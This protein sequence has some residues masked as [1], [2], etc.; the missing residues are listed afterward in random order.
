MKALPL[1]LGL[2]ASCS[3]LQAQFIRSAEY[4][5]NTDPGYGNGVAIPL[6]QAGKYIVL[7]A[8]IPV[9]DLLPGL[10]NL[11]VRTQNNRGYWSLPESRLVYVAA[12]SGFAAPDL[13]AMEYFFDKDPGIGNGQQVSITENNTSD[14]RNILIN[15][16]DL[17]P[18]FHQLYI[19]VRNAGGYWSVSEARRF[20]VSGAVTTEVPA[21]EYF[22]DTDPGHGGGTPLQLLAGDSVHLVAEVELP[23]TQP[24]IHYMYVRT[25]SAEGVWSL[26]ESRV[27]YVVH[28]VKIGAI[29]AAEYF[30]DTDPGFG[31]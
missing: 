13:V 14:S 3:F 21:A 19:R 15:L 25:R 5:F 10:H 6:A 31:S 30:F 9:S 8:A 23:F 22:F 16:E 7:Q 1:I 18:G 4:F 11:Y 17:E 26:V 27:L 20:F 2:L 28:P 12:V 29:T 24:G